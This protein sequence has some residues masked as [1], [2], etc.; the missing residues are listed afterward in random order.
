MLWAAVAEL[1]SFNPAEQQAFLAGLAVAALSRLLLE[2]Q[3]FLVKV[4]QADLEI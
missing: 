3:A 4:I 2:A 1:D